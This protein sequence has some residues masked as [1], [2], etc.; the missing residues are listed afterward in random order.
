MESKEIQGRQGPGLLGA[1]PLACTM[2]AVTFQLKGFTFCC[3]V[4]AFLF[5]S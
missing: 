2:L 4:S 3:Y 5:Y 1:A